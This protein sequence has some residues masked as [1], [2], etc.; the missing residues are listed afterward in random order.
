MI[1]QENQYR[2]S[3]N[4]RCYELEQG[5]RLTMILDLDNERHPFS[6]LFD[7]YR[8]HFTKRSQADYYHTVLNKITCK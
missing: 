1:H 4:H 6:V 5:E 8:R 3:E 7:G 2:D